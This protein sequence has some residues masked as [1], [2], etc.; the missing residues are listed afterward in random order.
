MGKLISGISKDGSQRFRVADVTDVV[1]VASEKH[2]PDRLARLALARAIA[3]V[4]VFPIEGKIH[5]GVSLQWNGRGPLVSVFAEH[6]LPG[7]I[8][9]YAQNPQAMAAS[10]WAFERRGMGLGLLPAGSLNVVKSGAMGGHT[11][12]QVPL[13][14]GEVDED[15]EAYFAASEQIDTRLWTSIV[16]NENENALAQVFA[17]LAQRLPDGAWEKRERPEKLDRKMTMEELLAFALPQ[18]SEIMTTHELLFA[19]GCTKDRFENGLLLLD[20]QELLE[21]L[22]LDHGAETTCQFCSS[23][24]AFSGEELAA[25]IDRKEKVGRA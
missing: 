13:K 11:I 20:E 1:Q 14:N 24:Y 5:D 3:C 19:C 15:L 10:Q 22:A 6:R 17:V 25:I 8:R 2:K 4:A 23:V 16:E 7:R 12:G 21:M 18:E 9:A